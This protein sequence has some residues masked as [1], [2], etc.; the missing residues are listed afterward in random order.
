[1]CSSDLATRG[2]FQRLAIELRETEAAG[3]AANIAERFD[4]MMDEDGK[5]IAEVLIRVSDGKKDAA[6]GIRWSHGRG[7]R[8]ARRYSAERRLSRQA[9]EM[10]RSVDI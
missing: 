9:R 7:A 10:Q 6:C 8:R 5:K 4:T 3:A 1:M 2:G